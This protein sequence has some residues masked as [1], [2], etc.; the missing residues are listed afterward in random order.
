MLVFAGLVSFLVGFGLLYQHFGFFLIILG[1][2]LFVPLLLWFF[3]YSPLLMIPAAHYQPEHMNI[4]F[5]TLPPLLLY[6]IIVAGVIVAPLFGIRPVRLIA[7]G[8]LAL[9]CIH[10]LFGAYLLLATTG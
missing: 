9:L 10:N 7:I 6:S 3:M 5:M 4:P 8:L 2:L 1:P